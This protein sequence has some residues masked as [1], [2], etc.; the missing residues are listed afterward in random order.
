MIRAFCFEGLMKTRTFFVL[1]TWATE[2]GKEIGLQEDYFATYDSGNK[3]KFGNDR[4]IP[5][6]IIPRSEGSGQQLMTQLSIE[7]ANVSIP[8]PTQSAG[9]KEKENS[10]R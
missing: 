6:G 8:R 2:I 1:K 5:P 4:M 7:S 10:Q 3:H 9:S